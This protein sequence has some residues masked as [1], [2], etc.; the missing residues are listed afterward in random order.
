M[1]DI[2]N[3]YICETYDTESQFLTKDPVTRAKAREWM[4]A[5]EGT[6]MVHAL[7]VG[8]TVPALFTECCFRNGILEATT[9]QSDRS[10]ILYARWRI[11]KA[12]KSYLPEME[13]G[14][15][16]NVQRDMAWLESELAA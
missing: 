11:P 10:Q 15:K 6:F 7:A 4:A 14:L 13:E 9:V 1:A 8:R 3:R 12:A 5:A 2:V 16:P